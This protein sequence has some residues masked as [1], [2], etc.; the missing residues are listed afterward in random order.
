MTILNDINCYLNLEDKAV[1]TTGN[2]NFYTYRNI[3]IMMFSN[4]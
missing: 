2:V 3:V 1:I 4:N